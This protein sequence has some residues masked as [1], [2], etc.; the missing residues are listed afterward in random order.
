MFGDGGGYANNLSQDYENRYASPLLSEIYYYIF[1]PFSAYNMQ[2]LR[3]HCV[4]NVNLPGIR[5]ARNTSLM[6]EE[7]VFRGVLTINIDCGNQLRGSESLV[8]IRVPILSYKLRGYVNK[9]V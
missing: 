2:P 1:S 7:I 3:F 5:R 8:N 6:E 4:P 9:Y